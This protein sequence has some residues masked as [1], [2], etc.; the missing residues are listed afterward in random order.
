MTMI[1]LATRDR[2]FR[3]A[4]RDY[5]WCVRA[6]ITGSTGEEWRRFLTAY[7]A[8]EEFYEVLDAQ[9]FSSSAGAMTR[10]G[11]IP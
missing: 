7:L 2:L 11:V 1:E 3:E 4:C 8:M 5:E 9:A 6:K 10:I